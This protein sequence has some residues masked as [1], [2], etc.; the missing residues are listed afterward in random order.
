MVMRFVRL[1]T[2]LAAVATLVGGIAACG[3]GGNSG[4]TATGS[5]PAKPPKAQIR[6]NWSVFFRGSTPTAERITLLQN[7]TK[8]KQALQ[9]ESKSPFAKQSEAS[10]SRVTLIDPRTAKVRYTILL[11][12]KP[13]LANQTGTAVKVNGLWKVSDK[14]FCHLLS[15][16]GSA[17]PACG[18]G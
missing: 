14:S 7:G 18:K 6:Q 9:A 2:S 3:G 13:A 12:G 15:L 16:K 4:S 8:Y 1:T 11:A 10:V 17:P 5:R